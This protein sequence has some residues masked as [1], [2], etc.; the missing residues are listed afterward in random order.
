MSRMAEIISELS[1][2][3]LKELL[4]IDWTY[5]R[6]NAE[7][8]KADG[9]APIYFGELPVKWDDG[10]SLNLFD[11]NKALALHIDFRETVERDRARCELSQAFA[12]A[13]R[14]LAVDDEELGQPPKRG[15]GLSG[16]G[17]VTAIYPTAQGFAF[18]FLTRGGDVAGTICYADEAA[19]RDACPIAADVLAPALEIISGAEARY[20]QAFEAGA[21]EVGDEEWCGPRG[22]DRV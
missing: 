11:H 14:I 4:S 20:R 15:D 2:D 5:R 19:A 17:P 10:L 18:D 21:V 8:L 3:D 22:G 16:P 6:L 7:G 1:A 12:A 9:A 13:S